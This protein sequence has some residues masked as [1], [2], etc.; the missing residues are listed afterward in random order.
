MGQ[1]KVAYDIGSLDIVGIG[2]EY[3][4]KPWVIVFDEG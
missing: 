1:R 3:M 4:K 2:I